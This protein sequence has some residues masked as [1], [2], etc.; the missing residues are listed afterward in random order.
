M[1]KIL[2]FPSLRVLRVLQDLYL[3]QYITESFKPPE[4]PSPEPDAKEGTT[5]PPT[6][7]QKKDRGMNKSKDPE[8]SKFIKEYTLNYSRIPVMILGI[9]GVD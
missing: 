5:E 9:W 7:K 1:R 3:Q 2:I 4:A 6:K 8:T